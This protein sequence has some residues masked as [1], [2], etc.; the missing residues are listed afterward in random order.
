MAPALDC[1]AA[2]TQ[3]LAEP[4]F[5]RGEEEDNLRGKSEDRRKHE[6]TGVWEGLL[7]PRS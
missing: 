5:R 2:L 4:V 7:D 6:K 3:L 1:R